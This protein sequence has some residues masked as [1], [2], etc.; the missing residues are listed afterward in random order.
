MTDKVNG[1]AYPG[2][3]VERNTAFVKITFNKDIQ[4]LLTVDL[5]VIGTPTALNPTNAVVAGTEATSVFGVVESAL[6]QALK[7]IEVKATVLGVSV[8]DPVSFSVDVLLGHAEGWFSDVAGLIQDFPVTPL[9]TVKGAKAIVTKAG[10]PD[11]SG[12]TTL[13]PVGALV[14]VDSKSYPGIAY[15]L[16]FAAWDGTMKIATGTP[17]APGATTPVPTLALGPGATPGS[18]PPG[19]STGTPGY[20]PA[21]F[22]HAS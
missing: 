19:S 12:V 3:W 22:P 5:S 18:T 8:Y 17:L 13:V 4:K 15:K 7:A 9:V 6:V 14:S 2:V 16:Q 11:P 21:T 1:A 20:Y 10:T